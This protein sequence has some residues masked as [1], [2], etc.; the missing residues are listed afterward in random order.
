MKSLTGCIM[1]KISFWIA[2][3][4]LLGTAVAQSFSDVVLKKFSRF[5]KDIMAEEKRFFKDFDKKST[6]YNYGNAFSMIDHYDTLALNF[7]QTICQLRDHK[8]DLTLQEYEFVDSLFKIMLNVHESRHNA[9]VLAFEHEDIRNDLKEFAQESIQFF[10]EK[11]YN[12]QHEWL[13]SAI[14]NSGYKIPREKLPSCDG[15]LKFI[16]FEQERK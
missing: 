8:Q 3:Q 7:Y 15:S 9:I 12:D 5:N 14:I 2:F 11:I 6:S 4:F 1:K 10:S 16:L 13:I